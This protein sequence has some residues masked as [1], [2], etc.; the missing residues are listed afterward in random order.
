MGVG[1]DSQWLTCCRVL[2]LDSLGA[3]RALRTNAGRLEHRER[4]VATLAARLLERPASE[5]VERLTAAGVP[6][7]VI[8][9]VQEA[10][11]GSGASPLTG[12]LPSVPGS[13]RLPPPRL[14]EH[15]ERIRRQLW[16][17]FEGA[18]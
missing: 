10:L 1:N 6:S 18:A 13:V 5:W 15:G 2:G 3:D 14:D 17:A 9:G 4:V 16:G 12:V 8:R 7:G 11:A